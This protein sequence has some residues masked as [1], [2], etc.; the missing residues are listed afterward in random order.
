VDT[1]RYY[2][3]L[4]IWHPSRDPAVFTATLELEPLHIDM[5]GRHRIRKGK[6]LDVLATES[7][8][9]HEFFPDDESRDVEDWLLDLSSRLAQHKE[10]FADIC[11]SGGRAEFFIGLMPESPNIG[12]ELSPLLQRQCADLNLSLSFDI[13]SYS[14][15]QSGEA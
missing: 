13:Y 10:F 15:E 4:R 8:W 14:P 5:A 1:Y 12:L 3:S 2:V 6:T 11:V 7:Y 9:T